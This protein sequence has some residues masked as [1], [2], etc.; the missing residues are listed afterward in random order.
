MLF[1]NSF[2][3]LFACVPNLLIILFC[4]NSSVQIPELLNNKLLLNRKPTKLKLALW[5][6]NN[7]KTALLPPNRE[8]NKSQHPNPQHWWTSISSLAELWHFSFTHKVSFPTFSLT[9]SM[10]AVFFLPHTTSSCFVVMSFPF[11]IKPLLGV[12]VG[13][14]GSSEKNKPNFTTKQT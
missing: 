12:V 7:G 6:T 8:K 2:C 1:K 13:L 5:I 11:P 14:S 4:Q 10:R 3:V 9:F